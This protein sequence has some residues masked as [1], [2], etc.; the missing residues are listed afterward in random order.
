MK[1]ILLLAIAFVA[2]EAVVAA[3]SKDSCKARAGVRLT[4]QGSLQVPNICKPNEND[5]KCNHFCKN[6]CGAKKGTC[7]GQT[8]AQPNLCF[9]TYN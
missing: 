7:S 5:D 3:G 4:S 8:T 1:F 6:E 2:F 9:C